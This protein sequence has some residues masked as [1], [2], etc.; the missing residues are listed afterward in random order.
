MINKLPKDKIN[1]DSLNNVCLD[2][3][4]KELLGLSDDDNSNTNISNTDKPNKN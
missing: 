3:D 1:I 2:N 4:M